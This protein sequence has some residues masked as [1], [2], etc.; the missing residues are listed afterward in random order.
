MN[1]DRI[2]E[3]FPILKI[4]VNGKPLAYLDNAATSQKPK[5]VIDKIYE[6]YTNYNS[7]IHR[8]IYTIAEK[9][10]EEYL[11]SKELVARLINASSYKNIIYVRNATEAINL[12]S[13]TWGEKNIKKGDLILVSEMEHHSNIVPWQL[14]AKRKKARLEYIKIKGNESI[15]EE[16]L[17]EKL[18]KKPKLVSITHVSNV[19]GTI[20]DVEMISKVAHEYGAKVL[21]DGAQSVPHMKV[22]VK[23]IDCDFLAFSGHKMLGPA[24][25]GVL[26]GKEEILEE[27]PPMLG[28]GDMIRSVSFKESTWNDLPWKFEA[29]TPNIEGGI[30]LG[31]AVKYLM[32]IGMEEIREHE[33]SLTRYALDRLKDIKGLSVY[34]YHSMNEHRAGVISFNVEGIHPHD[35]SEVFDSEGIAIRTGHHCA[36]PLT[37]E[38]LRVPATARMSFYLYNKEEEIERAIATIEKAKKMFTKQTKESVESKI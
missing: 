33:K 1:V 18:E 34:G 5:Q 22:D 12:V 11:N 24:G 2:R 13:Y 7:N 8:G 31:E 20:N 29:G 27:M 25:I 21:V 28:G 6:Y 30:G 3:D 15:D 23:K 26:Y 16:D 36:M 35:L 10:D 19:L 38:L 4:K 14:L 17:K 37:R 32:K 9:A